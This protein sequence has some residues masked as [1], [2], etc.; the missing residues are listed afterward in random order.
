MSGSC[1]G[2]VWYY[3]STG[4]LRTGPA[5]IAET[6]MRFDCGDTVILDVRMDEGELWL[7]RGSGAIAAGDAPSMPPSPTFRRPELRGN[8]GAGALERLPALSGVRGT[9]HIAALM[10][11][12]SACCELCA[13]QQP[14]PLDCAPS[15]SGSPSSSDA[16]PTRV[17]SGAAPPCVLQPSFALPHSAAGPS[18]GPPTVPR[19]SLGV[20]GQ[21]PLAGVVLR[22]PLSAR[23]RDSSGGEAAGGAGSRGDGSDA[24][25]RESP[26]F[27]P[28][29]DPTGPLSARSAGSGARAAA[30]PRASA[31]GPPPPRRCWLRGR[32][33][34]CRHQAE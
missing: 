18:L 19:L 31:L 3:T 7:A 8:G 2:K 14:S 23:S 24:S 11:F 33:A 1:E 17:G 34:C 27:L 26:D 21:R 12:D 5:P 25:G 20:V 30:A 6:G 10:F 15:A 4:W 29:P 28:T 22:P 32:P 9:V 16:S 13:L